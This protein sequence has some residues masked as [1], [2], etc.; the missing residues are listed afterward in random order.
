MSTRRPGR[1]M[2]YHFLRQKKRYSRIIFPA[3]F[4]I[5]NLFYWI[6]AGDMTT[7]QYFTGD[8]SVDIASLG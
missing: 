5:F 1:V 2:E 7:Y 6:L 3:L 8:D 4:M